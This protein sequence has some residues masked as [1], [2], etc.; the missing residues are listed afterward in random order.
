[1]QNSVEISQKANNRITIWPSNSTLGYIAEKNKNTN[2]KRDMHPDTHSSITH[3]SQ[4]M[5]AI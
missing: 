3:K 5:E 2:L 1:M 4:D